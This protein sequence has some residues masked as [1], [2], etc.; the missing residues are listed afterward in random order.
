M[1]DYK[2]D[3]LFGVGVAPSARD[4]EEV[5]NLAELADGLGLDLFGVQDHPY[6]AAFL[7]TWTL[8]AYMAAQT[9]RIHLFTDVLNIP[10]RPPAVVA[11]AAASL[12]ILSAGRV[13]LGLRA[14]YF[15]EPLVA[16]EPPARTGG[17]QVNAVDARL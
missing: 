5:L 7:D 12:D 10:L 16:I 17:E 15:L 9:Q 3:L 11:R 4:F 2:H 13:E 8:L 14:G 1:P 6:Q